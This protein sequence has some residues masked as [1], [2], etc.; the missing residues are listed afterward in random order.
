M[1][2][3]L[4]TNGMEINPG[5]RD[6]IDRRLN[7][8]LSRFGSR[9]TKATVSLTDNNGPKGG[10]DKSCQIVVRLRGLGD[11]IADVVDTEWGVSVDRA[12]TR[13]G[14]NVGRELERKREFGRDA[15]RERY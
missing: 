12:T 10:V 13:I 4:R 3:E 5:L 7:F 14:H 2:W 11:V 1:L 8:A 6:H 15:V 9:V